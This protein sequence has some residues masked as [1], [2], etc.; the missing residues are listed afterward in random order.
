[1]LT[2]ACAYAASPPRTRKATKQQPRLCV[3]NEPAAFKYVC[4]C[5]C[6]CA[7]V[8]SRKSLAIGQ[9]PKFAA[10]SQVMLVCSLVE[11]PLLDDYMNQALDRTPKQYLETVIHVLQKLLQVRL[12]HLL[13]CLL[14]ALPCS[15]VVTLC[16]TKSRLSATCTLCAALSLTHSVIYT[17]AVD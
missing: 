4:L 9:T 13:Q 1:M 14:S 7:R 6:I 12:C 10:I 11:G 17:A 2:G 15:Y 8:C 5:L 3:C 16:L